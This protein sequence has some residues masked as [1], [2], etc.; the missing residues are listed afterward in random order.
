MGAI[1][2]RI[3]R[4]ISSKEG[5]NR[6]N[7]RCVCVCVCVCVGGSRTTRTILDKSVVGLACST[8]QQG[9]TQLLCRRNYNIPSRPD[10]NRQNLEIEHV[11]ED[12]FFF[13]NLFLD[14]FAIGL[15]VSGRWVIHLIFFPTHAQKSPIWQ[16][17]EKNV[18]K[19]KTYLCHFS[20]YC[21]P[22]KK[23]SKTC[24]YL[25]THAIHF[26]FLSSTIDRLRMRNLQR[27]AFVYNAG[28]RKYRLV[29]IYL[30]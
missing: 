20:V 26:Y 19:I 29:R 14:T 1:P 21:F 12:D 15:S 6:D 13:T 17:C 22:E 10:I 24:F 11:C 9:W 2:S 3:G 27:L 5:Q 28:Y 16:L 25:F 4:F 8:I 23:L 7:A 30:P 18:K